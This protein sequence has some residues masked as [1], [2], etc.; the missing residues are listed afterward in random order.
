[1]SKRENPFV[2][3]YRKINGGTNQEKYDM[4]KNG[5]VQLPYYLDVELTNFCNFNCCFCPTG[6]K[7]MQRIRG[8]MPDN[9]VDAIAENVKK[10]NIPAV[11]FIRWGEPTLH[12][13]YLSI[14]EKV[15]NA[16]ALIHINTNGSLLDEAQIQKLLDMHLDSIKFSFQGADE[17]TYNEMREGGDYLR[18]L[19]IVRKFHEMRGERDYP[20]IQIST[21]LTGETVEQIEGFKSD[22]GDY[23]DY[24]NVGYTK[25]NH[26]NVDT[27]NI[28]EEEKKK[29]RRLQEHETINHTFRPVCVEAFDKLSINWNGDVTLCCG[30][31]DNFMII[32]NILDMDLK[33]IFNSRAADIYRDAIAKMQYGKIKCCSNCYETVPLTKG[34]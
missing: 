33:Q 14:I 2:P 10:Y 31:Y 26:L 17:G 22:I 3:I 21:T 24:Y 12:L 27:M 30:D 18:L 6:T 9:V 29:I 7:A 4:I 23:C 20:Y 11:R 8:H 15:K 16:G 1:M 13:N 19:D 32:G 34:E 28:D 25:L 5:D